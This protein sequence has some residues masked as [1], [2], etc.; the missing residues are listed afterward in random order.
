MATAQTT[1]LSNPF[2]MVSPSAKALGVNIGTLLALLGVQLLPLLIAGLALL[3]GGLGRENPVVLAVAVIVGI[4]AIIAGIAVALISA[5]TYSLILLASVENRKV[6]LR[7]TFTEARPYVWRSVGIS[8]LTFLAVVGGLLL[9]V[10]P[11][12]IFW[13]WFSLSSYVLVTEN[14]GAVDSMKRS[15]ELVRGRV[16]EMWGLAWLPNL[17]SIIPVFG[18]IVNVVLSIIMVP[19]MALR[20]RQLAA[21]SPE[22]RP[23]VHW[24]NYALIIG[25]LVLGFL[26]GVLGTNATKN[27]DS[28]NSNNSTYSY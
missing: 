1:Y 5:P 25:A 11:G 23:A 28:Y 18:G 26:V 14:L 4:A 2:K 22:N 3:V 10:I 12:L 6:A 16:W 20:Y 24:S 21:T 7:P 8:L 15:R 19:A 9:F 13:A 17:A 27:S